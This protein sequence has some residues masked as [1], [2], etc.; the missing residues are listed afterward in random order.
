LLA[1]W[2]GLQKLYQADCET[3]LNK[4]HTVVESMALVY[5]KNVCPD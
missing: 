3:A 1:I 2:Q 4:V 5:G